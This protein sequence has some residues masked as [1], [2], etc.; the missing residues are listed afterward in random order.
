VFLES[1]G[2][3][4][5]ENEAQDDVLIL[6]GVHVVTEFVG[7]LPEFLLEAQDGTVGLLLLS[8]HG[9]GWGCFAALGH[10]SRSLKNPPDTGRGRIQ[11]T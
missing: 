10:A 4:L 1:V 3:V 7:R 11:V 2:D 8:A 6:G 9:R 5:Q